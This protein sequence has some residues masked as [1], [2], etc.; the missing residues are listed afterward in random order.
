VHRTSAIDPEFSAVGEA[1]IDFRCVGW[2][3]AGI[4]DLPDQPDALNVRH[5][6]ILQEHDKITD[7]DLAG[8][9]L[10][11]RV[12]TRLRSRLPAAGFIWNSRKDAA[13]GR[14]VHAI[15]RA[16]DVCSR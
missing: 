10:P 11:Y 9:L 4:D 12:L 7:L 14:V 5:G 8:H 1:N 16:S 2:F 13:Q 15:H 3:V 6:S